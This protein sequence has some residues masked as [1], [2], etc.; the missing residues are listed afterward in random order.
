MI[1]PLQ[2]GY[3][4]PTSLDEGDICRLEQGIFPAYSKE[5]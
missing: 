3:L 4:L 5:C 2:A 1:C